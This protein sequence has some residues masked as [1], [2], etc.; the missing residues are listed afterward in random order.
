MRLLLILRSFPA[1]GVNFKLR[2]NIAPRVFTNPLVK[3]DLT[4]P[5]PANT[6]FDQD[7]IKT[8]ENGKMS[9]A[10]NNVRIVTC[11]PNAEPLVGVKVWINTNSATIE[12]LLFVSNCL[13]GIANSIS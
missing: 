11:V 9:Q 2:V 10:Y 4:V 13:D 1:A 3:L 5:H 8:I 12:D 7:L 6:P